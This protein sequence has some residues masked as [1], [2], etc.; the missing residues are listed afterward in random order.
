MAVETHT[1][2][3]TEP[4]SGPAPEST[5]A[6]VGDGFGSL[7]VYVAAV[8]LGFEPEQLTVLGTS[9][10]PVVT[11]GRLAGNLGQTVL[12]SESE[13]HF[14]P[15]DWPTFAQ[16]DAWSRRS[17]A[18]LAR[19]IRRRY[20]P[21]LV[22]ILTEASVVGRRL[23]WDQ[24]RVPQR[25]GWLRRG[26]EPTPHFALHGEDGTCIA[27][28]RHVML[29]LGRGPLAFPP[30]LARARADPEL[31]GGIVH[32]YEHKRY[33]RDRR[34]LVVGAGI[35]AANECANALAAG[36]NVIALRRRLTTE[37]QDLNVPRCL[38][39]ARGI[40]TFQ[41]LPFEQRVAFLEGILRG[42]APARRTWRARIT[43]GQQEG[44]YNEMI[45]EI[46][47]VERLNGG[48]RVHVSGPESP[49]TSWL[50]VDGVVTGTGFTRSV[51]TLP[52]VRRLVH[53]YDLPVEQGRLKLLSNCGVPKLDRDDSR[54]CT[55]GLIANTVIPNGDT[56]AGLKYVGRRFAAD[57]VRAEGLHVRRLTD[58]VRMQLS[59]AAETTAALRDLQPAEQEG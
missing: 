35:A 36:A 26:W 38:F 31:G 44:R 24:A 6:I 1:R 49:D 14:L 56:I 30:L 23:G 32:A 20:N 48:L 21:G 37:V 17:P 45:G 41:K 29:A 55:M 52:L 10:T 18:P 58:R 15:A 16:L 46:D 2:N 40:D 39:E 8:Y 7:I 47:A 3:P 12:R 9:E 27:R 57:C 4:I 28:A 50:E 22:D 11:Y 5:I 13:S 53:E 34:Y 51:L 33:E 43:A 25:V 42:T 19:S 59:L 54:L